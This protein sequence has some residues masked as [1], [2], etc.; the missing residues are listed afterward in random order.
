MTPF[1]VDCLAL[2]DTEEARRYYDSKLDCLGQRF[3]NA[4][5]DTI[6]RIAENPLLYQRV[7]RMACKYGEELRDLPNPM[8]SGWAAFLYLYNLR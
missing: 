1:R 3:A 5:A 8:P 2:C 6:E 4:V 7:W